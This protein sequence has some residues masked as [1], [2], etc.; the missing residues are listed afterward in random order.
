MQAVIV[1]A[2]MT[3]TRLPGKVLMD[4]AGQRVLRH[5]LT[6]CAAIP[7]ADIL[8]CAVPAGTEHD[9]VA[10]EARACGAE[11]VQGSE[12]DVLDRYYNAAKALG[13]SAVV[14]VTSDCPMID[15][16][17]CGEVLAALGGG[18]AA[19]YAANNFS[20]GFPHGLDCEAFTWEALQM[21]WKAAKLS[22]ER[23]HVTP[24]MRNSDQLRQLAID[25]PDAALGKER[26]TLDYPEDLAFFRALF[27]H[28]PA[29]NWDWQ[30]ALEVVRA[31]PEIRALNAAR[32]QR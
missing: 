5:V 14:R 18:R 20:H 4:L 3:S 17:L 1:Q 25:G 19:D 29:D 12:T 9:E 2:R 27:Q 6:R 7:G 10:R 31:H 30:S 13:A 32:H 16:N 24:W 11:V 28:L 8:C 22:D 26:W 23:E 15:P 21:A